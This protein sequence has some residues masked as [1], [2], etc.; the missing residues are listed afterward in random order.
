L[1][2]SVTWDNDSTEA[3]HVD[4]AAEMARGDRELKIAIKKK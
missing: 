2:S 1:T 4:G 3:I